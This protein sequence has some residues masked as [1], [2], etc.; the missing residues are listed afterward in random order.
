MVTCPF[1]A[2]LLGS[3][4]APGRTDE[5]VSVATSARADLQR[6]WNVSPVAWRLGGQAEA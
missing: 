4:P 2:Q 5:P 3:T 1:S 6:G